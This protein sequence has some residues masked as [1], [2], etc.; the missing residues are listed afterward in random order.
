[1]TPEELLEFESQWPPHTPDKGE[2]IRRRLRVSPPRYYQ[3]LI[4]A[5]SSLDGIRAHPITARE[6][7]D[8]SE[9]HAARR[10]RR[11]A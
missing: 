2:A 8:R 7:R 6:V 5:A 1:M 4:R 10:G 9:K 3:L 11:A